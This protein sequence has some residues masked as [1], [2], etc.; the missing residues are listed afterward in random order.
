[1]ETL[2][3]LDKDESLTLC[4]QCHALKDV[5]KEG[6][7]PGESFEAFYALKYPV[8]GDRPYQPDGRVRTF[9]YQAN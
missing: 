3:Y 4:F 6:Y 2:A 9:A 5:V 1:M 7:L 8:L